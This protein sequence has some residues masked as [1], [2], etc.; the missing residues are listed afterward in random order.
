VCFRFDLDELE[1]VSSS[2]LRSIQQKDIQVDRK[3]HGIVVMDHVRRLKRRD[4]SIPGFGLQRKGRGRKK[5]ACCVVKICQRVP[6]LRCAYCHFTSGDS[7]GV[8]SIGI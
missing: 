6:E 3:K 7:G 5:L 8:G 1:W 2:T 4:E